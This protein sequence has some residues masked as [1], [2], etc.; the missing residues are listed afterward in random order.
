MVLV[1]LDDTLFFEIMIF[2]AKK[3]T[4]LLIRMFNIDLNFKKIIHTRLLQ[5]YNNINNKE[6]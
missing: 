3:L 2:E 1:E 4:N 5:Q 6:W